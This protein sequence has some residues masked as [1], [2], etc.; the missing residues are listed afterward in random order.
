MSPA[1]GHK[2][3]SKRSSDWSCYFFLIK[4]FKLLCCVFIFIPFRNFF[5]FFFG[6]AAQR[7]LV[8]QPGAEPEPLAVKVQSLNHRT[9]R[10][11]PQTGV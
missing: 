9:P 8:P 5:F 7:I 4:F 3:G 2:A 11:V 6:F 1:Q 10:E